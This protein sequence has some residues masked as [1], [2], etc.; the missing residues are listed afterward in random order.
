[1]PKITSLLV[2]VGAL[3]FVLLMDQSAAITAHHDRRH[4]AMAQ[5]K[6]PSNCPT[7]LTSSGFRRPSGGS[8]LD[9][10]NPRQR[11]A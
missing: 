3:M 8:R 6:N 7:N 1:M 4:L 10:G 9:E 11:D 2:K 5:K